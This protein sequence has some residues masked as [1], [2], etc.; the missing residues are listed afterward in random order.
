MERYK[1]NLQ[2]EREVAAT[3]SLIK[4]PDSVVAL[5]RVKHRIDPPWVLP[6]GFRVKIQAQVSYTRYNNNSRTC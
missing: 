6:K 4:K 1:T 5:E 3:Y 2:Q